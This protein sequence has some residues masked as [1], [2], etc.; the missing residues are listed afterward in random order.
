MIGRF[1]YYS[2]RPRNSDSFDVDSL[3]F[4]TFKAAQFL[5][6]ETNWFELT[7]QVFTIQEL[8]QTRGPLWSVF[9]FSSSPCNGSTLMHLALV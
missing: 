1:L 6:A 3:Q 2:Y 7:R 5:F 8:F 9:G 4:E